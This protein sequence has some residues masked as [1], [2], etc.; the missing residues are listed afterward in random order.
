MSFIL[1]TKMGF[2]LLSLVPIVGG[3]IT[4]FNFKLSYP[5]I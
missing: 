5:P 1:N 3:I 4:Y 2:I